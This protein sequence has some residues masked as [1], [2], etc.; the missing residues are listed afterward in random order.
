METVQAM[1]ENKKKESKE[2]RF[3][4]DKDDKI[5]NL[6]Q[7]LSN[8]KSQMEFSN[9]DFNA[10]KT[11]QYEAVRKALASIYSHLPSCFG[12]VEECEDVSSEQN[13]KD[14]ALIKKGYTRVQ[15]KVKEVRQNFSSAI[16]SGRRSGSGKIVLEY[17]DELVQIWGGSPS[18]E[19]LPFGNSTDDINYE[20]FGEENVNL[21]VC[22]E[23]DM[24][25]DSS[26]DD[27]LRSSI[28]DNN[29]EADLSSSVW[30][31]S[32]LLTPETSTV[33]SNA[34]SIDISKRN[35]KRR[36]N[37][38]ENPVPK[39]IDNKRRHME[40]Q[41]SASQRDQILMNEAK[42]DTQFKR[43]IAE[44]IRHS[45]ETFAASMEQ[46]SQSIL[47]VAQGLTRSVEVMGQAM[48]SSTVGHNPYQNY[49]NYA[50]YSNRGDPKRGDPKR[51][52]P[53]M[54]REPNN[55]L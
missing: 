37:N 40:R 11:K 8:Y 22:G 42:E 25:G 13:K 31:L 26:I 39:L 41:L 32:S 5:S 50:Q 49:P 33:E 53:N 6:I 2:I 7:C 19:P 3:R 43:D 20:K 55:K 16:T 21:T 9:K 48:M 47:Q 44:A 51:G 23:E 29:Y 38:N 14:K 46:I 17:Y 45:N 54:E 4:W 12:P 10:D 27:N 30:E 35:K 24:C 18:T 52:D 15:E 34:N 36:N 28:I 1:D